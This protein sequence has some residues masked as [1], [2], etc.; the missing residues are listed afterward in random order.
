MSCATTEPTELCDAVAELARKLCVSE[1]QP[2]YLRAFVAERLI[3]L[4]KKPG[5]R[6]IGVGEILRRIIG[7]VVTTVFSLLLANFNNSKPREENS[8]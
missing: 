2:T 3:P 7:K 1:V 4:D 6:P 5:V 8:P